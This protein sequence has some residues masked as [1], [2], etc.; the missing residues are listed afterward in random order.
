MVAALLTAALPTGAISAE[1][2]QTPDIRVWRQYQ[3]H[4]CTLGGEA[5]YL[6]SYWVN[7]VPGIEA[8]FAAGDHCAGGTRPEADGPPVVGRA[9]F[10]PTGW[11][12]HF[13]ADGLIK[14]LFP[15]KVAGIEVRGLKTD[16]R[17]STSTKNSEEPFVLIQL[18]GEERPVRIEPEPARDVV[19]TRVEVSL[20]EP[21]R[22]VLRV[23]VEVGLGGGGTCVADLELHPGEDKQAPRPPCVPSE[24]G[25]G[26]SCP[27]S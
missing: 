23:R 27:C 1:A 20:A 11:R 5:E 17:H 24:G 4:G 2:G 16:K 18:G 12:Y 10:V 8:F 3:G 19:G 13:W 14:R 21:G 15:R 9:G 7:K 6:F 22:D 26:W 25:S